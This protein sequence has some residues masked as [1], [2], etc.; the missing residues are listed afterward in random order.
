MRAERALAVV[1]LCCLGCRPKPPT[2]VSAPAGRHVVPEVV[3]ARERLLFDTMVRPLLE[4]P[5]WSDGRAYEAGHSLMVP[6]HAAFQFGE[7]AWQTAFADHFRRWRVSSGAHAEG[8]AYLQYLYLASWYVVLAKVHGAHV[9]LDLESA[10]AA[11]VSDEL[12]RR[13][14]WHWSNSFANGIQ[15]LEWK[16]ANPKS[17]PRYYAAIT[18]E[19]LFV[20]ALAANVSRGR[21]SSNDSPFAT[22][23]EL[24]HRIF[25][26]DIV[27]TNDGGWLLQ[28]GAWSDHP[29]YS[30]AGQAAKAP[31][32]PAREL[33]DV[34]WDTSHAARFPLWLRSLE[35]DASSPV[36]SLYSGLRERFGRHFATHVLVRPDAAFP[37]FRTTNYIDGRNGVFRWGY[38]SL[39]PNDG[40]GPYEASG[41][42]LDGWWA[43]AGN[44]TVRGAYE[45]LAAQYPLPPAV[46]ILYGGPTWIRRCTQDP[47][48]VER[49]RAALGFD[50]LRVRLAS[51]LHDNA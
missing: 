28:P 19:E 47:S 11:E 41:T 22:A 4:Q 2:S 14:A 21:G 31:G 38:A 36:K 50:E 12:L 39:G 7:I 1:L 25:T 46:L 42:L 44:A 35:G 8:I 18:D 15:R 33:A 23:R 29:A 17:K 48:E 27:T 10:L 16:L 13:P 51:L 49:L 43:F 9:P 45:S 24:A 40:Y 32:L 20:L 34:A 26:E 37:T 6:L 5:L 30:R 3:G